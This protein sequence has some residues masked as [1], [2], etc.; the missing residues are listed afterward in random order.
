MAG[1]IDDLGRGD[2]KQHPD[3]ARLQ[4]AIAANKRMAN[5]LACF[6]NFCALRGISP[7]EVDDEVVQRFFHWLEGKTLHPSRET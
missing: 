1:I 5:G 4:R 7:C 6:M 2:A 3:W